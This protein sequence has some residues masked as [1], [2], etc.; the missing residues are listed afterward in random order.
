MRE[1]PGEPEHLSTKYFANAFPESFNGKPSVAVSRY[2]TP[3]PVSNLDLQ[4][5]SVFELI[6]LSILPKQSLAASQI[7]C[8][9]IIHGVCTKNRRGKTPN[10]RGSSC[11]RSVGIGQDLS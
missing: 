9:A 7:A 6:L 8:P 2:A 10:T 5:T 3:L 4:G 11:E 1:R